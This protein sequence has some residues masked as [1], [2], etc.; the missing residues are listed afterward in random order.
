[1]SLLLDSPHWLAKTAGDYLKMSAESAIE[2]D[3]TTSSAQLDL[4]LHYRS[5]AIEASRRMHR[6]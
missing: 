4:A 2:G 3:L 6:R 1:M 5:R